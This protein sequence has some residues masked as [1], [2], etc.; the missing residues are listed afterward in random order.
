M[1]KKNIPKKIARGSITVYLSLILLLILSLLFTIIEGARVSTAKVFAERALTTA[2]DSVFAEYYGPLWE[3]YHIFGYNT[4]NENSTQ[5]REQIE[6]KLSDYMSFTFLPNKNLETSLDQKGIDLYDLSLTSLAV[7]DQTKLID[8]SGDLINNEAVNYM[9]YQELGNGFEQLLEKMSLLETPK[10]VS[11]IYENK[12]EVEEELV[13]IDKGVLQ[14]M[15]LLDGIKTN[16][17]GIELSRNGDLQTTEYFI[18]K[19]C[20]NNATKESVGI[21]NDSVFLAVKDKYVNPITRIESMKSSASCLEQISIQMEK[22]K[23]QQEE[24]SGTLQNA[25][26][27]LQEISSSVNNSSAGKSQ[28]KAI[29]DSI[30]NMAEYMETLQTQLKE[31]QKIKEQIKSSIKTEMNGLQTLINEL[32]PLTESAISITDN[33]QY[34]AGIAEK[35]LSEYEEVIQEQKEYLGQDIL[36]GLEEGLKEMKHY[37][38]TYEDG[39]NFIKMMDELECDR[40]VLMEVQQ[41][42]E[43][44]AAELASNQYQTFEVAMRNASKE[45]VQYETSELTLD[46]STLILDK[47]KQDN[48]IL[49]AG[50]LL[51]SG[52]TSLVIDPSSLSDKELTQEQLPSVEAALSDRNTDFTAM[53]E[54]FFENGV[55][56]LENDGT[57][58][59]YYGFMDLTQNITEF[60]DEINQ[61]TEDVLYQEYLKEHFEGFPVKGEDTSARKPSAL[62]YELEYLLYGKMSDQENIASSISNIVFI[63]MM[64]DF[65]SILGDKDKCTEAKLAAASLVGFTGLPILISVVQT[66]ILLTWSFMEA[67]LD[68]CALIMGK[69]IPIIKKNILLQLPELFL[70]NRS[71]LQLKAA[72][73]TQTKESSFSYRDYLRVI[74]L[75]KNKKTLTCRSMDLMQENINL[76]YEDKFDIQNCIFGLEAKADFLVPSKFTGFSFVQEYLDKNID[77]F[78]FSTET[79]YSY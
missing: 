56:G 74:M 19:I 68:V 42:L 41:Y 4:G 30:R 67:L 60:G 3:E 9:K 26:A 7:T 31:Q 48:P 53:I 20:F 65:A 16:N 62:S 33:L 51:Q 18:K 10:N 59:V 22:I 72:Q 11:V 54:S 58:N 25:Q 76:R 5:K 49:E 35:V 37:T 23:V 79:A 44:G 8:Y 63:R 40:L 34:K 2:M 21:N 46:Y 47:S 52:I 1:R 69:E 78:C 28:I 38:S 77:G 36:E 70:I 39:Y 73:I 15:E 64:L 55:A 27:R 12:S 71:F 57:S 29:R 17:I 24:V 6:E 14:L 66:V 43:Q 32:I 13:E 61:I 45:L 50:N 75:T